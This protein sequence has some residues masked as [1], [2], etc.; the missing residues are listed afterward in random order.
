[1]SSE[2]E[3]NDTQFTNVFSIMIGG[4][5]VLT[6]A[7]IILAIFMS[8]DVKQSDINEQVRNNEVGQTLEPFGQINI[9]EAPAPQ[10][11]AEATGTADDGAAPDAGGEA[12]AGGES[13]YQIACAACHTSGVAGSPVRGDVDA[14]RDR[15]AKGMDTL[16]D[17]AING[18]QGSAGVMPAKGG[19]P[20]LSDAEVRAAVDY[21]IEASSPDTGAATA[22]ADTGETDAAATDDAVEPG[23]SAAGDDAAT[24]GAAEETT[25]A[26]EEA[27]TAADDEAATQDGG[28]AAED[29]AGAGDT[30]PA[31]E[32]DAAA[33][34][35]ES[36]RAAGE[37]AAAADDEDAATDQGMEAGADAAAGDQAPTDEDAADESAGSQQDTGGTGAST[38]DD[39]TTGEQAAT[40]EAAASGDGETAGGAGE[41]GE[42]ALEVA[43]NGESVY[44]ISCFACHAVGVAGAPKYGDQA[45][46]ADRI[47]KGK[48]ALY[49][50]AI[51]GY[52]G[53]SGVMPAKGGNPQ[54]SDAEVRAAVD[55]MIDAVR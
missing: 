41:A 44:Q 6:I 11:T 45:A 1:M 29:A 10:Q 42:G 25:P 47:A 40:A 46:W 12:A 8:S 9:G 23:G 3:M 31:A 15:I 32:D 22:G 21:M 39:T 16:Y 38:G 54:L 17:H 13:V 27:A 24:A 19:N 4:L 2:P 20:A 51:T 48:E 43:D 52:Q 50:S 33:M 34:A 14:W 18:F 35:D 5:I 49:E 7:L 30:A 37:D 28:M 36:E 26:E 55:Y 53:E